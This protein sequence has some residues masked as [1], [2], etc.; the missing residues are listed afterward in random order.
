MPVV[1]VHER[2][3]C[4]RHRLQVLEMRRWLQVRRMVGTVQ[5][6]RRAVS[7]S[8][9]LQ[10]VQVRRGWGSVVWRRSSAHHHVSQVG[11]L[12]GEP[13]HLGAQ[14]EVLRLQV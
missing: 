5:L 3:R 14:L 4:L 13:L 9:R 2:R 6:G 10:R 12:S 8:T 1:M 7:V 11:N